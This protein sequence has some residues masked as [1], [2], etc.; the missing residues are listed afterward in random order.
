MKH[1]GMINKVYNISDEIF[2]WSQDNF[3][4]VSDIIKKYP[5]VKTTKCCHSS[6]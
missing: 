3:K 1:P 6:S 4:R 2:N 5:S